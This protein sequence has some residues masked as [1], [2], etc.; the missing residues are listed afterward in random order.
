M[1]LHALLRLFVYDDWANREA[2]ASLKA[3]GTPPPRAVQIMAHILAAEWLWMGRL[4]QDRSP[5]AVWPEWTLEQGDMEL[6]RLKPAWNAYLDT[7]RAEDLLALVAYVNTVGQ[8]WTNTVQD[9]LT[10]VPVHSAYH[11]GQIAYALGRAGGQ[12]AYTDFIHAVRR[13]FVE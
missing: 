2:L 1:T 13:G 7:L 3:A 12:A 6:G 11:R 10:H 5:V 8:A 4:K 9:I